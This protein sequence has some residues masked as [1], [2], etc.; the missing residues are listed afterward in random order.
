[1]L[2]TLL[3]QVLSTAAWQTASRLPCVTIQFDAQFLSSVKASAFVEAHAEVV[4]KTAS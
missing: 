2:T 3:D 4:K 1:M